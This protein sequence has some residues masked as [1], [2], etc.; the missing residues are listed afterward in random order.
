MS[1]PYPHNPP[2]SSRRYAWFVVFLLIIASLVAFMNRQI[3]AIVVD[4]MQQDLGVGEATLTPSTT[5]FFGLIG[6]LFLHLGRKHYALSMKNVE[7]WDG[8]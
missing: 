7:S 6:I 4:P 3:G 8:A 1:S 5:S 2:Y